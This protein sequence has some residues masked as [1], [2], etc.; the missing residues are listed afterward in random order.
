MYTDTDTDTNAD[1]LISTKLQC[2]NTQVIIFIVVIPTIST[3]SFFCVNI[4]IASEFQNDDKQEA[5]NL[6]APF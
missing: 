1:T 5:G 2:S 6:L 4:F 3:I